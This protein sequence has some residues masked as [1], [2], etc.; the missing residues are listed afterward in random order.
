MPKLFCHGFVEESLSKCATDRGKHWEAHV[1]WRIVTIHTE[2]IGEEI[3]YNMKQLNCM[4]SCSIMMAESMIDGRE[5]EKSNHSSIEW[6]NF[7]FVLNS[8][9][10]NSQC[11]EF[12]FSSRISP[13]HQLTLEQHW[14]LTRFCGGVW[15]AENI[16]I[17][18]DVHV[19]INE[20]ERQLAFILFS[21][22]E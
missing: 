7:R 10:S 9:N 5:L 1:F 17:S 13:V 21:R 19:H 11:S 12:V 2:R 16:G 22:R 4:I 15:I 8:T 3:S 6:L 14:N 18:Q 20:R